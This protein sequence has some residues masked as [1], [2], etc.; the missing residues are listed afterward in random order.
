MEVSVVCEICDL[1]NFSP[2]HIVFTFI[3]SSKR[4]TMCTA[5][6]ATA[7]ISTVG[8]YVDYER[9]RANMIVIIEIQLNGH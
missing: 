1:A 7:N 2:V 9:E 6:G 4:K 3:F 8:Y 5:G